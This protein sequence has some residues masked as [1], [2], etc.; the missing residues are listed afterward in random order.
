MN[1]ALQD[2]GNTAADSITLGQLRAMV[3]SI[4]KPK[5]RTEETYRDPNLLTRLA[6]SF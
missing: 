2:N 5:V 6:N 4:P 1:L 3:G